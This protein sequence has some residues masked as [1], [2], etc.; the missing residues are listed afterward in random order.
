MGK[1]SKS[2]SG[3][4][5]KPAQEP[6]G[7][8]PDAMG[9]TVVAFLTEAISGGHKASGRIVTYYSVAQV[10]AVTGLTKV[11]ITNHI[12]RGF[13]KASRC[14]LRNYIITAEAAREAYPA[15]QF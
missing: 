7:F 14:G 10:A 6:D 15:F 1:R 12:R 4:G 2:V 11:T 5:P 3:D 8:G 9:G 13:L